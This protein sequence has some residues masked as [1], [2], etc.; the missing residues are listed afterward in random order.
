MNMMGVLTKFDAWARRL[1]PKMHVGYYIIPMVLLI[2]WGIDNWKI[3]VRLYLAYVPLVISAG[4][5][6]TSATEISNMF[7][8]GWLVG[9]ILALAGTLLFVDALRLAFKFRPFI[10]TSHP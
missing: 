9:F 3:L 10:S 5:S 2:V 4:F 7:A 6:P 8:D 1:D